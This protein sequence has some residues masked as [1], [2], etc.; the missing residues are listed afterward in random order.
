M[1]RHQQEVPP[2]VVVTPA[3]DNRKDSCCG[4]Q[5]PGDLLLPDAKR[6]NLADVNCPSISLTSSALTNPLAAC[7]KIKHSTNHIFSFL[8]LPDQTTNDASNI[9]ALLANFF[10]QKT[11]LGF[12]QQQT[13]FQCQTLFHRLYSHIFSTYQVQTQIKHARFIL[14]YIILVMILY[15][16]HKM[17]TSMHQS[18]RH[19]LFLGWGVAG[20]TIVFKAIL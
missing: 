3:P 9:Y 1:S 8:Y 18:G 12:W 13:I 11:T 20:L 2:F 19:E 10:I 5:S 7:I 15:Q 16:L 14:F 17:E 6:A 4:C